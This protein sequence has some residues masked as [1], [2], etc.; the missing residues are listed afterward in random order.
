M[1]LNDLSQFNEDFIKN[2]DENSNKGYLL[3]VDIEYLKKLFN[4][5]KDLSF[6]PKKEKINKCQKLVSNI[7]K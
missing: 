5:L 6:L 3:E 2:Y 4:L 1:V 7:K